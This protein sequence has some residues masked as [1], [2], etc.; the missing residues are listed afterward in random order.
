[1]VIE[2]I[3]VDVVIIAYNHEK[4]IEKTLTG[5][6]AQKTNFPVRINV[7]NDCSPDGL[8]AVIKGVIAQNR[9]NVIINYVN[10]PVN[11]GMCQNLR[12]AFKSC[13]APYIALCDGDDYWIDEYKLQK[14]TDFLNS[15]RDVGLVYTDINIYYE[16][17]GIFKNSVFH[18]SHVPYTEY[19]DL[20]FQRY[21]APCSWVYRSDLMDEK[22][23]EEI[24]DSIDITFVMMLLISLKSK[25]HFLDE[26]TAVYRALPES[27]SSS[28]NPFKIYVREVRLWETQHHFLKNHKRIDI[29]DEVNNIFLNKCLLSVFLYQDWKTFM[30]IKKIKIPDDSRFK[31][32]IRLINNKTVFNIIASILKIKYSSIIKEAK[33][34]Y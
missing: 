28:K 34:E 3:F 8:D 33:R 18:S 32:L 5:V 12:M 29:E 20:I 4:F 16:Q 22:M 14:Q 9:T 31:L 23:Y 25:I 15:H 2:E 1:M 13:T 10:Q 6:L 27:A 26:V 11:L 30:E 7:Y 21:I 24:S 19:K 17:S